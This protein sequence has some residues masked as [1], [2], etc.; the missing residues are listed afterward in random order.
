MRLIQWTCQQA[1][2]FKKGVVCSFFLRSSRKGG[3]SWHR[4]TICCWWEEN[5]PEN[6]CGSFRK[7]LESGVALSICRSTKVKLN[8]LVGLI[9]WMHKRKLRWN[10]K[11]ECRICG[12][13]YL[14]IFTINPTMKLPIHPFFLPSFNST[15]CLVDVYNQKI[16]LQDFFSSEL[17]TA[18]IPW[19]KM[20]SMDFYYF[21]LLYFLLSWCV[22]F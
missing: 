14:T 12:F 6:L 9:D 19:V 16:Y 5:T 11:D 21:K 13:N 4:A 22:W 10:R 17:L 18:Q 2:F 8:R 7:G 3:M 20:Q 15:T 1:D